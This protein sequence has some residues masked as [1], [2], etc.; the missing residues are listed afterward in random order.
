MREGKS[1]FGGRSSFGSKSS[2]GGRSRDGAGRGRSRD[3]GDREERGGSRGG[4]RSFSS[5]RSFGGGGRS[6]FGGSRGFGERKRLEMHQGV[7]DSC[8]KECEVPFKPTGSKPLFCSDCFRKK[9]G[10]NDSKSESSPS[11]SFTYELDVINMKLDKI[12]KKLEI[13]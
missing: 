3:D 10:G 6:S 8:G 13:E 4:G 11:K 1:K 9:E 12:M 7:C 2:F 5:G